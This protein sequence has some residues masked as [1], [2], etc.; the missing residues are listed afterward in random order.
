GHSLS[1]SNGPRNRL[2]FGVST[3]SDGH[4]ETVSNGPSATDQSHM[5]GWRDRR[6]RF[7]YERPA[8]A[9]SYP[10]TKK[11]RDARPLQAA[12]RSGGDDPA[13]EGSRPRP[14]STHANRTRTARTRLPSRRQ[15]CSRP[16]G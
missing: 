8:R 1:V 4:S 10:L 3:S 2:A 7:G 11:Q 12:T 5:R 6:G 14:S 9:T 15:P 16:C 13:R